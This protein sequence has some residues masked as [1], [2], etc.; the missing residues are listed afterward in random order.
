MRFLKNA[1]LIAVI[2]SVAC[3]PLPEVHE[4]FELQDTF[5]YGATALKHWSG[6]RVVA[7]VVVAVAVMDEAIIVERRPSQRDRRKDSSIVG[8]E[9]FIVDLRGDTTEF[10]PTDVI[11]PM[12]RDQVKRELETRGIMRRP[13]FVMVNSRSSDVP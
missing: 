10:D 12:S 6:R 8:T 11:G 9:F 4:H 2:A 5:D 7:P 1:L 13:Q 3:S